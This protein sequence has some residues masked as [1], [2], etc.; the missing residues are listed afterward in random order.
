VDFTKISSDKQGQVRACMQEAQRLITGA[1]S[2]NTS[3]IPVLAQI[4]ADYVI[5][6]RTEPN[7]SFYQRGAKR[8]RATKIS[9]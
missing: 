4:V 9:F 7:S 3:L 6:D 1:V 2:E 8:Q 5:S